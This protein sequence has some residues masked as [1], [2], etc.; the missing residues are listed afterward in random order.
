M[1]RKS[2]LSVSA[3]CR[4]FSLFCLKRKQEHN[5]SIIQMKIV[6]KEELETLPRPRFQQLDRAM[7][8]IRDKYG[9]DAIMRAGAMGRGRT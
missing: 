6:K 3:C 1:N 9:A 5:V 2:A 8:A 7:D 4:I